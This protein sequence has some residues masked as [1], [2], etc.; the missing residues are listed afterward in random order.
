M[1]L[2]TSGEW[3]IHLLHLPL[4]LFFLVVIGIV[5]KL[6][7][8]SFIPHTQEGVL[9]TGIQRGGSHFPYR[10]DCFI[11]KRHF[12]DRKVEGRS[13]LGLWW[14]W[15]HGHGQRCC[16]LPRRSAS[17]LCDIINSWFSEVLI[18]AQVSEKSSKQRKCKVSGL[19]S[20]LG[21]LLSG[22]G[23]SV[24]RTQGESE[25]CRHAMKWVL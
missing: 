12:V 19:F 2:L 21:T 8:I 25:F 22:E 9:S 17:S 3:L 14:N 10:C 13:V 6:F 20:S 4:L 18:L 16:H 7:I 15:C 1:F 11:G 24:V 5:C 23:L